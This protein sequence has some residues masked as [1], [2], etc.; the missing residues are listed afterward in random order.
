[1]ENRSQLSNAGTVC[2]GTK[3]DVVAQW[4]EVWPMGHTFAVCVDQPGNC[5]TYYHVGYETAYEM[6]D[7]TNVPEKGTVSL[8]SRSADATYMLLMIR[9]WNGEFNS[10]SRHSGVAGMTKAFYSLSSLPQGS[11][12]L[13]IGDTLVSVERRGEHTV[14]LKVVAPGSSV[15]YPCFEDGD[16]IQPGE[17]PIDVNLLLRAASLYEELGVPDDER[18]TGRET[19]SQLALLVNELDRLA[20]LNLTVDPAIFKTEAV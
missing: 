4:W 7:V 3:G 20:Q 11:N 5:K 12:T 14:R 9:R 6:F 18:L 8:W 16:L 19:V 15:V 1:M 2:V 10:A 13:R 17:A